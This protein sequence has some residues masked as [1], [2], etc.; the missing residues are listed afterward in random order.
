MV[1]NLARLKQIIFDDL[2]QTH[3]TFLSADV[4]YTDSIDAVQGTFCENNNFVINI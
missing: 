2:R 3:T 1:I 4:Q